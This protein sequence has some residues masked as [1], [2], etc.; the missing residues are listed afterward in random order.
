M[1]CCTETGNKYTSDTDW[2]QCKQSNREQENLLSG[3]AD[4]TLVG[5]NVNLANEGGLLASFLNLAG[6]AIEVKG[7]QVDKAVEKALGRW[8]IVGYQ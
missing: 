8:E 1:Q 3:K 5:N 4:V 6:T 2:R 7:R